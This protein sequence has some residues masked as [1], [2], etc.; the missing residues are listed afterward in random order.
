MTHVP[1]YLY[2]YFPINKH[3]FELLTL[4]HIYFS[5]VEEFNDPLECG[6][7]PEFDLIDPEAVKNYVDLNLRPYQQYKKHVMRIDKEGF[8]NVVRDE[9]RRAF[10]FMKGEVRVLCLSA[11]GNS[12]VM[13]SHY[14]DK[15]RGVCLKFNSSLIPFHQNL[16]Y[17]NYPKTYPTIPLLGVTDFKEDYNRKVRLHYYT[18]AESW[19]YEKEWRV[20][21]RKDGDGKHDF[22]P[23]MISGII[24]GLKTADTKRVRIMKLMRSMNWGG[25]F[26]Q[27]TGM[28]KDFTLDICDI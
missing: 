21:I 7:V 23:E 11:V 16:Q 28:K 10:E 6:I 1:K 17:V 5:L 18:K 9:Y 13:F 19:K 12:P 4:K 15:H 8:E 2:K 20:A 25:R 3:L 14:A 22:P 26:Q 24:F 27:V